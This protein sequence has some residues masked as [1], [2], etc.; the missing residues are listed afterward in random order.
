M[1]SAR[2]LALAP[3]SPPAQTSPPPPTAPEERGAPGST[4]ASKGALGPS[5]SSAPPPAC[6]PEEP[7]AE[8]P[9]AYPER[10]ALGVARD[11]LAEAW[12]A[13][14]KELLGPPPSDHDPAT[15][16]E[17]WRQ[18][19]YS[20]DEER[21]ARL[22][23]GL[24]EHFPQLGWNELDYVLGVSP[25]QVLP[26]LVAG[27]RA[28]RTPFARARL[29]AALERGDA[30]PPG[31][32][33][34]LAREHPRDLATLR[35]IAAHDPALA[36]RLL[37]QLPGREARI[38]AAGLAEDDDVAAAEYLRLCEE[39]VSASLLRRALDHSPGAFEAAT[40]RH[41]GDPLWASASTLARLGYLLDE[42]QD[43][44][45]VRRTFAQG[46]RLL[47]RDALLSALEGL[48]EYEVRVPEQ[49]LAVR[50]LVQSGTPE[51]ALDVLR[52]APAPGCWE[53]YASLGPALAS[54]PAV[55][56]LVEL[57]EER[58]LAVA[59]QLATFLRHFHRLE[60]RAALDLAI[61]LAELGDRAAARRVL[62]LA[63]SGAQRDFHLQL[64]ER[65]ELGAVSWGEEEEEED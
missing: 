22:A 29:L 60:G 8:R 10:L 36:R 11:P 16:P 63:P 27:W 55:E 61:S 7:L 57:V 13:A 6:E 34:Q 64:L 48:V 49:E 2:P 40:R 28:T 23:P 20:L 62:L 18:L 21:R 38:L 19:L 54:Q 12:I 14:T 58:P 1:R 9:G 3:P 33:E 32:I 26:G 24:L 15:L 39:R 37:A 42:D 52:L 51:Q 4:L 44:S 47:D 50:Q 65:N 46:W 5:E 56:R 41:L 45:L 30:P 59:D 35:V 31:V 53:L 43:R 17:A 25:E